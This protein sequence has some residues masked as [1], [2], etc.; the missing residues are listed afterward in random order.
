MSTIQDT[1]YMLIQRGAQ[2]YKVTCQDVK[3]NLAKATN[4]CWK[5]RQLKLRRMVQVFLL[6]I[7]T[8]RKAATSQVRRA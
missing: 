6:G 8:T 2:S 1:D 7:L 3:N 4:R 5:H